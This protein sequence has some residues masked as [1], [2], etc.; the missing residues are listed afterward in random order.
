[1]DGLD[2]ELHLGVARY[3]PQRAEGAQR[4]QRAQRL[5]RGQEVHEAD[6]GDDD[7]EEVEP[8]PAVFEVA[9]EGEGGHLDE[10]LDDED[11]REA[12]VDVVEH[13]WVVGSG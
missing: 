8:V 9:A 7:D 11:G 3:E 6:D 10:H 1:M 2:Y 5:E 4:A 12:H 13:L